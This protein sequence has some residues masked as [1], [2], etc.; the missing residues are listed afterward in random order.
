VEQQIRGS[1]LEWTFLRLAVASA[2]ALQWAF[3]VPG[4]LAAGDV[5][6]G[7]YAEAAGSP[8][9][10]ADFAAVAVAALTRDEHAGRTYLVTGPYSLTHAEQVRLI[11][12]AH[13]RPLRF[14]E[15]DEAAARA[16]ISPY[17][18]ADVLF[19]TWQQHVGTPAPV[20]DTIE[21][22]TGRP[23]RSLA[24]WAAAYPV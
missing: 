19:E 16:A 13:G 12:E 17:A 14:E 23:P 9:H 24:E 18:P 20:T 8:V 7:P 21:R 11:G 10:P 6:R 22:V 4:Q 1:G 15:L 2:D 3:D 5:V